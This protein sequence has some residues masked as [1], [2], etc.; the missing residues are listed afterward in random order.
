MTR[1]VLAFTFLY[2]LSWG[3]ADRLVY[4]LYHSPSEQGVSLAP[5][6]LL[7]Q[8]SHIRVQVFPLPPFYY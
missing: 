1:L 8:V 4:D 6:V 3:V 7:G 5:Y 2:G